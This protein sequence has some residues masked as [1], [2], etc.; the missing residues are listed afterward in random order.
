MLVS[1]T[2]H[3]EAT[4][5]GNG[6]T[7][8]V[9]V[10]S[11]NSRYFHLALRGSEAYGSL[12]AKME[13]LVRKVIRRGTVNLTLRIDRT[14][15]ATDYW[16]NTV[17]L[18]RYHEQLQALPIAGN[19]REGLRLDALLLLPGVVHEPGA[20]E[21]REATEWPVIATATEAAVANLQNMRIAEGQAM[22]EDLRS[23][24]SQ[25]AA[26]LEKVRQ[27]A[28][29][30]V[31]SYQQRLGDRLNRLL[32]KY[33]ITVAAGDIVREV[34]IFA[35]RCDISEEVVRM[36]SHLEQFEKILSQADSAG[37]KLEFLIQEMFRETNTIGAKANDAEIARS[38]VDIKTCIERMR[39]MIQNVE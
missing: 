36:G 24:C 7:V 33:D 37:K 21:E 13:P 6:F 15:D 1:M 18:E 31:E 8:S 26:D 29:S 30:V 35:D 39:E 2:G 32:E 3:G 38:V 22:A 10:R 17:V 16:I 28:P 9:D 11:V 23:N 27:R 14:E 20:S 34:G 5:K 12:E 25:I 4:E 19:N